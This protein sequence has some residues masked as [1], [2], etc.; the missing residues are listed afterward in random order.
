METINNFPLSE[1]LSKMLIGEINEHRNYYIT[2]GQ[3]SG[4]KSVMFVLYSILRKCESAYMNPLTYLGILGDDIETAIINARKRIK[5]YEIKVDATNTFRDRAERN[6]MSFGKYKGKTIEEIFDIDENYIYW[7]ANSNSFSFIK[8]K[9]LSSKILEYAKIA[10]E[11]IISFNKL[12]SK[13]ILQIDTD[14]VN[15]QLLVLSIK[16]EGY[17]YDAP[18]F[19]VL[20]KDSEDNLFKYRGSSKKITNLK[21]GDSIT[22]G[23]KVTGG[24]E[25]LGKNYNNI[26][27]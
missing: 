23:C 27:L 9:S 21:E 5:F 11:N 18:I 22:L 17:Y 6:S 3:S 26:K 16:E 13:P 8:S 12:N 1:K 25:Y 10:K 24:Y 7:L 14:K 20:L 2:L 15:R 4:S 19:N